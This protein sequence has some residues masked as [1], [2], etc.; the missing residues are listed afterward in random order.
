MPLELIDNPNNKKVIKNLVSKSGLRGD[1]R[2][3]VL[4]CG[5]RDGLSSSRRLEREKCEN[6]EIDGTGMVITVPGN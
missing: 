4:E 6:R 5:A 3:S 2:K 1:E